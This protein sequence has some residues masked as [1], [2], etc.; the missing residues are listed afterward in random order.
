MAR[1]Q[2]YLE[3]S[4]PSYGNDTLPDFFERVLKDGLQGQE[5]GDAAIFTE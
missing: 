3:D 2:V 4:T 5:L 1:L